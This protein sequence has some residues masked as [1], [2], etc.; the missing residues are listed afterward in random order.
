MSQHFIHLFPL[1]RRPTCPL[2]SS[3]AWSSHDNEYDL[4]IVQLFCKIRSHLESAMGM[5]G[6]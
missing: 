5:I 2:Q 4:S 1:P 3:L 6:C